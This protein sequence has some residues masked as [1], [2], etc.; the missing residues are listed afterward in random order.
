VSLESEV[1]LGTEVQICLPRIP[2][3]EVAGG[4][5]DSDAIPRGNGESVLL[6]EDEPTVRKLLVRTLEDLGY[7][8]TQAEDGAAALEILHEDHPVDVILSDVILPGAYSGPNLIG[9]V[10]RRRPGVKALLISGYASGVLER[11]EASLEDV[12]LLQKPFRKGELAR[13]LRAVLDA[14]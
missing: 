2:T 12:K 13:S 9:E 6:V 3:A 11:S 10:A 8:V 4:T 14:K 1:D 7:A 5:Q